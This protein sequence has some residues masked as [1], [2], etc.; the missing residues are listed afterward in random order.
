VPSEGEFREVAARLRNWGRWGADDEL[1]TLNL[2]TPEAVA[3]S[4]QAVRRGR[5]FPLG[6]AFGEQGIWDGD[7]YR[8]NPIHLMTVDGGDAELLDQL[9]AAGRTH[10]LAQSSWGRSLMRFNDDMIVMPLQSG[11]QWDALSHVYYDGLMYNGVPSTAVTS[12]GAF[13]NSIDRVDVK[14][15]V[16]RAVLLDV[17]NGRGVGH[18]PAGAVIEPEE[19]D[20]VVDAQRV[21]LRPGD[22]VAVRTGWWQAFDQSA[23][24]SWRA[25]SPGLSWRCAS[26][27]RA[28]DVAAVAADNLAVEHLGFS[29]A[30]DEVTLPLHLLCLVDMG[31]MLGELWW[32][33]DLATDCASDGVYTFHLVAAPLRVTGAVGSPVNP[34]ALK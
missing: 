17:A 12:A 26:W 33:E 20:A 22:V 24:A 7:S 15:I 19:L 28:N 5:V 10:S 14:G 16:A 23:R 11:S 3:A 4:A 2:I 8:R 1:G 31:M 25:G 18:L 27:L 13:R 29:L 30:G 6:T 21:T 9:G 34:I 32:L